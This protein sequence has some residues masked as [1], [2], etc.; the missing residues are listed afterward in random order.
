ME[1]IVSKLR[2]RRGEVVVKFGV[3]VFLFMMFLSVVFVFLSAFFSLNDVKEKANNAVLAVA[4]VNIPQVYDGIR[5]GKGQAHQSG[6]GGLSK[7][8]DTEDVFAVL[9]ESLNAT[10]ERADT[11]STSVYTVSQFQTEYENTLDGN[12][13]FTSTF[14]VTLHLALLGELIPNLK[15]DMEVHSSYD[16]KF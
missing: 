10:I 3:I 15:F 7:Y 9:A 14:Q 2:E 12:L 4:A 8:I 11:F 5:E 16:P 13:N 1:V 6:G